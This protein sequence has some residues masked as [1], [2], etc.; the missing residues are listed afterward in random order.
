MPTGHDPARSAFIVVCNMGDKVDKVE[1]RSSWKQL[2]PAMRA[3]SINA[4]WTHG[5]TESMLNPLGRSPWFPIVQEWHRLITGP[6]QFRSEG[7]SAT[8]RRSSLFSKITSI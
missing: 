5:I 3:P 6:L 4:C 8:S 1:A 7:V 2:S